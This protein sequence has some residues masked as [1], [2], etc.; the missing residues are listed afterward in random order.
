MSLKWNYFANEYYVLKVRL[1]RNVYIFK[2]NLVYEW[3]NI[4][5]N[6]NLVF[7]SLLAVILKIHFV[8]IYIYSLSSKEIT[9][10]D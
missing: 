1:I 3:E 2:M 8:F 9:L 10:I 7:I 4:V 5:F 6:Y